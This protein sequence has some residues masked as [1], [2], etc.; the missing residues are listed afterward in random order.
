M[1]NLGRQTTP[2]E[3]VVHG[4]VVQHKPRVHSQQ[5]LLPLPIQTCVLLE[6][7]LVEVLH[8]FNVLLDRSAPVDSAREPARRAFAGVRQGAAAACNDSRRSVSKYLHHCRVVACVV[9]TPDP[10]ILIL[11]IRT[12]LGVGYSL[13]LLVK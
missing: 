6:E 10:A 9:V 5:L 7:D 8:Q 12:A 3:R 11:A 2:V 4:R 1:E 13:M